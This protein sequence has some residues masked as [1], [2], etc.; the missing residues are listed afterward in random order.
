MQWIKFQLAKERLEEVNKQKQE[1]E[2][3]TRKMNAEKVLKVY[4][5][6]VGKYI[7]PSVTKKYVKEIL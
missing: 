7:D 3:K 1:E 4:K 5:K 2:A 6:G